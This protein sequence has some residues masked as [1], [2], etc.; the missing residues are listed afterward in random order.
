MLR[1][2][3]STTSTVV[4]LVNK[5]TGLCAPVSWHC[6][7]ISTVVDSILAA[8]CLSLKEDQ[9]EAVYDRLVIEKIFGMRENSIEVH[10]IVDNCGTVDAVHS[11]TSVK[12]KKLRDV[13]GI[14]ELMNEGE[15]TWV[16]WCAKK[17]QLADCMTKR[18]AAAWG[19]MQVFRTGRRY[20]VYT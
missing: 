6:N 13:A 1:R 7:R 15:V 20:E 11:T 12:A 3:S 10:G 9:H 18:G 2:Y 8:E 4:L 14:K 5:V 17:E 19:L 16:T